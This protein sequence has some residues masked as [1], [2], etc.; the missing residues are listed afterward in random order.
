MNKF[1][2]SALAI[3]SIAVVACA[4]TETVHPPPKTQCTPITQATLLNAHNEFFS[5]CFEA[6]KVNILISD[7]MF[8]CECGADAFTQ[9]IKNLHLTCME[10]I[11]FQSQNTLISPND[12]LACK[13]LM[14]LKQRSS[15]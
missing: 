15:S 9:N 10:G 5:S 14:R 3:C 11:L 2:V 4:H 1:I 7:P 8:F 12:M 6:A 13:E